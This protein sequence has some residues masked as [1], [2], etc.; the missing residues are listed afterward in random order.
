M[1]RRTCFREAR[2]VARN[3]RNQ[4]H[5]PGVSPIVAKLPKLP[6]LA[7]FGA[8]LLLLTG[9]STI[10]SRINANV[11]LFETLP[12]DTQEK[13]RKGIVEVGFTPEMVYIAMGEPNER[14]SA[15]SASRER[16]TWVYKVYF[17]DWV[18]RTL[19]GYERIVVYD[20]ET[21]KTYVYHEPVYRDFYRDR[22]EERVRIMF[23]NGAVS[24]IEERKS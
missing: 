5:P 13:L 18:G 14:R 3:V 20:P 1:R 2:D 6:F 12:A 24:V 15:R 16:T 17:R 11:A 22:T 7:L 8:A 9:C 10:N 21:K 19:V 23:E 4:C